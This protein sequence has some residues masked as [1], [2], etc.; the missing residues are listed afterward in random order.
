MLSDTFLGS[1][2]LDLKKY[3]ERQPGDVVYCGWVTDWGS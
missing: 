1:F 2:D 3:L